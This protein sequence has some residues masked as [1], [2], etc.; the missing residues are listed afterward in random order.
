M[1]VAASSARPSS[2]SY[3]DKSIVGTRYKCQRQIPSWHRCAATQRL[4]PSDSRLN[5]AR[6][7][8]KLFKVTPRKTRLEGDGTWKLP[9]YALREMH[10]R[11]AQS[12]CSFVSGTCS[13][14]ES[15]TGMGMVAGDVWYGCE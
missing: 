8:R 1:R 13:Y 14:D 6:N 9:A 2:V 10:S 11:S 7:S 4:C 12:S 3:F 15:G 5:V